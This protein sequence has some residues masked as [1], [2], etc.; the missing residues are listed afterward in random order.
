VAKAQYPIAEMVD[1]L[2]KKG[3]KVR[4]GIHPVAGKSSH[5]IPHSLIYAGLLGRFRF[6]P[7]HKVL[8]VCKERMAPIFSE[9]EL[10]ISTS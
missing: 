5:N 6:L 10:R 9:E 7:L 2:K 4:F 3:K 8:S 1:V